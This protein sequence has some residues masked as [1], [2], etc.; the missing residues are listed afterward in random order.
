M[1]AAKGEHGAAATEGSAGTSAPG[2][3]TAGRADDSCTPAAEPGVAESAIAA[4]TG[5]AA[6][7]TAA[8]ELA[9]IAGRDGGAA[10][11]DQQ[12]SRSRPV[13]T[14]AP[15]PADAWYTEGSF[16]D[17]AL[18]LPDDLGSL[19]GDM[20]ADMSDTA[21]RGRAQI[22]E[23]SPAKEA[24]ARGA[25]GLEEDKGSDG[26]GNWERATGE[27]A[28]EAMLGTEVL[29]MQ[30]K[31]P[32]DAWAAFV[33]ELREQ[34]ASLSLLST[35]TLSQQNAEQGTFRLGEE[36]VRRLVEGMPGADECSGYECLDVEAWK[37]WRTA[38]IG[39]RS[40]ASES[41]GQSPEKA[42]GASA[43]QP[44]RP[45]TAQHG[46]SGIAEDVTMQEMSTQEDESA[47][48]EPRSMDVGIKEVPDTEDLETRAGGGKAELPHGAWRGRGL[49]IL[50][51]NL[52]IQVLIPCR[53]HDK[54]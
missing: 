39:K 40:K 50:D 23:R 3:A 16:G 11:S 8:E 36:P 15:L 2:A 25:G 33:Q 53:Y 44:R 41:S 7:T 46:G 28:A 19:L 24:D 17:D 21:A 43:E 37:S 5:T 30:G 47:V 42:A 54:R 10:G 32:K 49:S 14:P 4:A 48:Q 38:A 1:L 52:L 20:R 27:A 29:K 51:L 22:A 9:S 31:S 13:L 18:S 12:R 26:T 35:V 6:A 34:E 45:S